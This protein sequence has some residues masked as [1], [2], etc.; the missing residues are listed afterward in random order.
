M[1]VLD[2]LASS[3]DVSTKRPISTYH[4]READLEGNDVISPRLETVGVQV[5]QLVQDLFE[6]WVCWLTV[7]KTK[8]EADGDSQMC[9]IRD[10]QAASETKA[11]F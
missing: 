2:K 1:I 4:Y 5:P 3:P 11:T 8:N 6:I 7:K 9:C 10:G